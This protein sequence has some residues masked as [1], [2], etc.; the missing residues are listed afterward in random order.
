MQAN[1]TGGKLSHP[2]TS[3]SSFDLVKIRSENFSRIVE[4]SGSP[5]D[6]EF[7]ATGK[8]SEPLSERRLNP[9]EEGVSI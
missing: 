7:C 2:L 1:S 5:N 4:M 9:I 8:A 3:S 6:D